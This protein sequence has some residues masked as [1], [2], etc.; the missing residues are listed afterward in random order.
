[1]T[2]FFGPDNEYEQRIFPA[3][4][5]AYPPTGSG[6]VE[7]GVTFATMIDLAN[8]V[9]PAVG[10]TAQRSTSVKAGFMFF[11]TTLGKP[12]WWSG[13]AWHDAAGSSV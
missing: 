3:N 10:T 5:S 13:M 7:N 1:M 11:D 2:V 12:I 4:K 8:A 9:A 6:Q